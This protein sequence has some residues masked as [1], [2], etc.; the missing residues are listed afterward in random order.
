MD[1]LSLRKKETNKGSRI[2]GETRAVS[3]E[4][5]NMEKYPSK[6]GLDNKT[7]IMQALV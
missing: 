1:L 7:S 2:Q 4:S 6:I 3:K 5:R